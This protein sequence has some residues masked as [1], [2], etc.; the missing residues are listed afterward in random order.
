MRCYRQKILVLCVVRELLS[1]ILEQL[2]SVSIKY[3]EVLKGNQILITLI[4]KRPC[5]TEKDDFF[6]VNTLN[7]FHVLHPC[8]DVNPRFLGQA[9]PIPMVLCDNFSSPQRIKRVLRTLANKF[10]L[11]QKEDRSFASS[12]FLINILIHTKIVLT[13]F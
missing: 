2:F 8:N 6:L 12:S 4:S 1:L 9:P 11:S 10:D 13:K 7:S 3:F 5:I